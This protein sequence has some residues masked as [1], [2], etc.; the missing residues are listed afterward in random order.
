MG[1][2]RNTRKLRGGVVQSNANIERAARSMRDRIRSSQTRSQLVQKAQAATYRRYDYGRLTAA[3]DRL[4]LTIKRS[5]DELLR[6]DKQE[7]RMINEEFIKAATQWEKQSGYV[8]PW[9]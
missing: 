4:L 3:K 8:A 9:R 2:K 6:L 5:E 1:G 7:Q